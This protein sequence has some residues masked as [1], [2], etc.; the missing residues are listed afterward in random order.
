MEVVTVKQH[1]K[2]KQFEKFYIFTGPEIHI[3][4]IY[5]N[6]ISQ[7]GGYEINRLDYVTDIYKT[8]RGSSFVSKK[9]CYVIRDDKEFAKNEDAW[10]S[11]TKVLGN[12]I[13]ILLYTT[14]DKRGKFFKHFKDD[15]VTFEYLEL[16]VLVKYIQKEIKLSEDNAKK[17]AQVC[18]MD[19]SRILLEIDKIKTFQN[20]TSYDDNKAFL[21]L[22]NSGDI[23]QPPKDAIFDFV[24][25]VLQRKPKLTFSLFQ[26]CRDVGE[27]NLVMQSVMYTQFK[28]LLQ[29]QSCKSNDVTK[30]TGLSAWDI[31][32]VKDKKGNYGTGELVYNLKFLR[33]IEKGIK[34][35]EIEEDICIDYALVNIL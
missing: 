3:Q 13:L 21:E 6:K 29:Y 23:Y 35:G 7:V 22:L 19:Y 4:N 34:I 8:K 18:E 16:P 26:Q 14:I 31:K 10:K 27:A 20:I 2:T 12:N 1:I 32:L 28:H 25:A 33:S 17:L 30:S 24:D 9:Y 15:I 5:I 11:I